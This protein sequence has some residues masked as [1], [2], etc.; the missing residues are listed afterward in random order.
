MGMWMGYQASLS[1]RMQE[2][3]ALCSS[4]GR[5]VYTQPPTNLPNQ[6]DLGL[7]NGGQGLNG[8]SIRIAMLITS[9][10]TPLDLDPALLFHCPKLLGSF[11]LPTGR[12]LSLWAGNFIKLVRNLT[13]H[14]LYL[15]NSHLLSSPGQKVWLKFS[16]TYLKHSI[17]GIRGETG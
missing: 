4:L 17:I 15:S 9:H 2:V 11:D 16:P 1:E 7:A 8:H 10:G 3:S 13:N 6:L 12:R 5:I 14:S